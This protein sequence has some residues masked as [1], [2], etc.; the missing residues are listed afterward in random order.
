VDRVLAEL[1]LHADPANVAGMARYGISTEGTLGVS[2]PTLRALARRL[3]KDHELALGLW[4]SGIH[5][6]RVL[7]AL[8]DEPAKVTEAQMD[9]WVAGFDSWDVCDQVTANLFDRTPFAYERPQ[10]W[11]RL[12]G[13]FAKRAA[14]AL[15]AALAVHDRKAPDERFIPFLELIREQADDPRNYVKKAVSWAL[16]QIGKRSARLHPAALALAEE[17]A[18]RE[19]PSARWIGRDANKELTSADVLRRLAAP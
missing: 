16:R 17:L 15:I 13:E 12:E 19:S 10:V 4:Q 3:G 6:A 1:R 2:M 18:G 7:A 14:F 8:V 11:S 5:E 9:E